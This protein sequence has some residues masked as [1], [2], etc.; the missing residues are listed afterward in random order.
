MELFRPQLAKNE[1]VQIIWLD[2]QYV[3]LHFPSEELGKKICE[4]YEKCHNNKDKKKGFGY[5]SFTMYPYQK[6]EELCGARKPTV[7]SVK[8]DASCLEEVDTVFETKR[9]RISKIKRPEQ[10]ES[11]SRCQILYFVC[12]EQ[13]CFILLYKESRTLSHS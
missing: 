3:L 12:F 2:Q 4:E 8:R 6:Y 9:F 11:Q 1:R 7:M 13:S 5:H 10:T